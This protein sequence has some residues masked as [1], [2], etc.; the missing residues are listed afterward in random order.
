MLRL[1]L[2]ISICCEESSFLHHL[3]PL[4]LTLP[5]AQSTGPIDHGLQASGLRA[6]INLSS[7]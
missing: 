7:L 6:L 2:F 1:L 3:L 5:Q 4:W